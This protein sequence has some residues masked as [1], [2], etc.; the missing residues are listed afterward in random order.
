MCRRVQRRKRRFVCALVR[1]RSLV[2]WSG[3]GKTR[4]TRACLLVSAA[5][6]LVM[7][8]PRLA[9][10]QPSDTWR[11]S[12]VP[13]YFWASSMSGDLTAANRTVPVFMSFDNAV[14]NLAAAFTFHV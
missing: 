9:C 13:L 10:A 6:A 8:A 11:G 3:F 1:E 12:V 7:L 5:L 2:M 4:H 14:D